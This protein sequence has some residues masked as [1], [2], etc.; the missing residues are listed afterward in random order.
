MAQQSVIVYRERINRM[1]EMK[2]FQ[3]AIPGTIKKVLGVETSIVLLTSIP[4]PPPP[5]PGGGDSGGG[6]NCPNPGNATMTSISN[7]D[8]GPGGI[9][10]Q[11]FQIGNAVNPTFKYSCAAYSHTVD[12]IAMDG[13]TPASIAQRLADAVNNTSLAEWSQYGSNNNNYKPTA[14]ANGDQITLTTDYQHSFAAWGTGSCTG[15]PPPPPPGPVYDPLFTIVR[16]EKA[17][18]LSLQSPDN[19]DIFCQTE[20]FM[21]DKNITYGDF[22]S[23][24]F[25]DKD[26]WNFGKKRIAMDLM[27]NTSSPI[28]EAYYKD[29]LGVLHNMNIAYLLNIFIWLEKN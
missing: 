22:T 27:I 26:E 13:D 23:K 15:A 17:G 9:R 18:V 12:V 2:Y 25:L 6:G 21:Q 8:T 20:V 24:N 16:N 29:I 28:L 11:V 7:T 10:T 4:S 3:I 5:D 1:G 14:V 19:T